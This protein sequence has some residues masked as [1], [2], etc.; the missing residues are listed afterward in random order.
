MSRADTVPPKIASLNPL[1]Q[2][3]YF[4]EP[5]VMGDWLRERYDDK[6]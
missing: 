2:W 3:R 4:S 5:Q 1:E 6:E